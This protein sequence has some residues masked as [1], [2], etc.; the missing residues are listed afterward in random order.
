MPHSSDNLT[1][2]GIVSKLLLVAGP[3]IAN[4]IVQMVYNMTDMFWLGRVGSNAVAAA[5]S[6]GMFMW[7]SWGFIS[8]SQMGSQIGVSQSLG[9]G[10]KKAALNYFQ[11]ALSLALG[12]GLLYG[13]LAFI[14]NKQLI[15]F[16]HYKE[17]DVARNASI[18]LSIVAVMMPF[19]FL[20]NV[21][22]GSFQGSGNSRL[23][24]LVNLS[25]VITNVVLDPV[26]ILLLN[27]GVAGAA[28]A[29]AIGQAVSVIV[30]CISIFG[31]HIK[32]F[33]GFRIHLR[34]E[35][36]YIVQI[37]K[38]ALP[39]GAQNLFFCFLSMLTSRME[40]QFGAVAVA[41]GKVGSQVE[42][43]TWMIG[44]GYG[45]AL[46]AFIGQN[47]GAKKW[48]RIRRGIKLSMLIMFSWTALI[49]IFLF[50]GGGWAVSLFLKENDAIALGTLY[51]HIVAFCQIAGGFESV[52]AGAFNGTGRTMPPAIVV[53]V[54]NS[55]RVVLAWFLSRTSLGI[56][57]V[58]IS[59]CVG[60]F[61][62]GAWLVIWYLVFQKKL[63]KGEEG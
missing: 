34:F 5:G 63:P 7:L 3:I 4:Q 51:V 36:K 47:F 31:R 25:G 11:N 60:A 16:F 14:F 33:E 61:V 54:C 44:G 52:C 35:K 58:W 53:I 10:D 15:G 38:W 24:F 19:S 12:I 28:I 55:L 32:P 62:R 39:I 18:Y 9:R 2:G 27:M 41:A 6:A 21:F 48:P 49:T 17:A 56:A 40:V 13:A 57:G 59:I 29:T 23:P 26:F 50:T 30:L 20:L 1:E 46:V 37:L 43:L 22:S 8:I 42:S 45:S